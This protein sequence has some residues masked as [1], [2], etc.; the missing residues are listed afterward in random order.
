MGLHDEG[1]VNPDVGASARANHWPH[2]VAEMR[3]GST[4]SAGASVTAR[5]RDHPS[6][7]AQLLFCGAM[8]AAT[9]LQK[10]H[11]DQLVSDI[12]IPTD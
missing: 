12:A 10:G 3:H 6:A 2:L 4:P 8:H 5:K 7:D 1:K 9:L 11:G